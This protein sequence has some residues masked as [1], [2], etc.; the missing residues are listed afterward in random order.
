MNVSKRIIGRLD[1]KNQF[2]IKGIQLEGLRKIGDP[3]EIAT[4]LYT[5]GADELVFMDAVA[6]LYGRNNL[7]NIISKACEEVFIP[8]TIGGGIRSLED[9]QTALN[10]GADKVAINTAGIENPNFLKEAIERFGSQCIVGS[11][12]CKSKGE[13]KWEAYIENGREETGY[14]VIEWLNTLNEIGVGE[15][16]VTSIDRDGTKKGMDEAL[17]NSISQ[18]TNTPI[19]V[20][21][22]VGKVEHAVSSFKSSNIDAI[23]MASSLH[24][25]HFTILDLKKH[26]KENGILIRQ[27]I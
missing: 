23:A 7:F 9:I 25:D 13:G 5:Q 22:G 14:D 10:N 21:G 19:M 8:I 15:L 26:L 11:I 2:V 16:F 3:I 27:T 6:S 1:I 18:N 24:Y 17:L 12:E 4:K 20:S